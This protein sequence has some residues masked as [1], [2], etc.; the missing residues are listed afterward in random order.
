L[1]IPYP[2]TAIWDTSDSR[3]DSVAVQTDAG[4]GRPRR[5][6]LRDDAALE[7]V[8]VSDE[9]DQSRATVPCVVG[10]LPGFANRPVGRGWPLF[11]AS[12]PGPGATRSSALDVNHTYKGDLTVRA[13]GGAA[14]IQAEFAFHHHHMHISVGGW[15]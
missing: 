7:I 11:S 5:G 10:H 9:E 2:N 6:F 15:R 3:L 4:A 13:L 14:P 1:P 12:R 8:F